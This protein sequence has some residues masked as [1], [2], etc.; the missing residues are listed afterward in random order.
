MAGGALAA[1]LWL[2]ASPPAGAVQ[3]PSQTAA[4]MV[5][6]RFDISSRPLSAAIEAYALA[7]GMQVLY[8]R[9]QSETLRSSG[10][11]GLYTRE[12]ALRALLAGTDLA[13]DFTGGDS[14]VLRP[15]GRGAGVPNFGPPPTGLTVM[16]LDTLEVR[17]EATI[18]AEEGGRLDL[19]LYGGLVRSA[20]HKALLNNRAT[21][22]GTYRVTLKL[23]IA[24]SGTVEQLIA[25]DSSGDPRRDLAIAEALRHV[26]V[27]A[28]P[29]EGLP[30]PVVLVVTSRPSG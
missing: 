11:Q 9:P 3:G 17:G 20:V 10:I 14:V 12:A 30:Q 23:W 15:R 6:A 5:R 4:Q 13:P 21:A 28:P 7:T 27:S 26:V 24:P 16:P 19:N 25:A 29:P 18:P 1:G 22:G 2:L 8:D